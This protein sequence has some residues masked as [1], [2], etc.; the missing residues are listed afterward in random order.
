[1]FVSNFPDTTH[2]GYQFYYDYDY[3]SIAV[4]LDPS[5]LNT[6]IFSQQANYSQSKAIKYSLN[7]EEERRSMF[8]FTL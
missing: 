6:K 1:M 5:C 8:D 2:K 7:S 3:N 4:E